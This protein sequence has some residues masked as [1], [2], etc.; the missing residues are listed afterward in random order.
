M[1]RKKM[2]WKITSHHRSQKDIHRVYTTSL[3]TGLKK[4]TAVHFLFF[5]LPVDFEFTC[6]A[7]KLV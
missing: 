7:G 5:P 4:I 1:L 3:D 2:D 6:V